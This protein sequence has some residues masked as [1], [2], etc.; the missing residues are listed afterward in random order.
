MSWEEEDCGAVGV[1]WRSVRFQP[2]AVDLKAPHTATWHWQKNTPYFPRL[3]ALVE[4]SL[5]RTYGEGLMGGGG[6]D[7][8][9]WEGKRSFEKCSVI[10][11]RV[12]RVY[13][14]NLGLFAGML[15]RLMVGVR[16]GGLWKLG[17]VGSAWE[18]KKS[19]FMSM[20]RSFTKFA[21]KVEAGKEVRYCSAVL[22]ASYN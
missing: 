15:L 8:A 18:F 22:A 13:K 20:L 4:K 21:A 7:W 10:I 11:C 1:V 2:E 9:W 14:T 17:V 5:M 12:S 6:A 16:G 3:C 19:A